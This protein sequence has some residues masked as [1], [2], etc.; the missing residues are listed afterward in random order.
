MIGYLT[1]ELRWIIL[2][3]NP[4]KIDSSLPDAQFDVDDSQFPSL[5]KDD[6]KVVEGKLFILRTVI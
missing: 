6:I 5:R 4:I 3:T 2:E 1:S